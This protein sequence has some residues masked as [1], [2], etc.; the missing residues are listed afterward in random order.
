S[1]LNLNNVAEAG[2]LLAASNPEHRGWEWR[3]FMTRLDGARAVLRHSD[4][5]WNVSFNRDG[6]RL[7]SASRDG[8]FRVWDS[9]TG[10]ELFQRRFSERTEGRRYSFV[11]FLPDGRL[12]SVSSMD[13]ARIWKPD[14]PGA[15]PDAEVPV[16]EVEIVWFSPNGD[17][18]A[19]WSAASSEL[20]GWDFR[21]NRA[22]ERL[23]KNVVGN[24]E[25]SRDSQLMAMPTDGGDFVTW[26]VARR[27]VIRRFTG[28][29][30]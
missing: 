1:A 13:K 30:I 8:G 27:S 17:Y 2:R 3:H 16:G 26:D 23:P 15:P 5:V 18:M 12:L 7:A 10:Q 11:A 24:I 21:Q 20:W 6:T 28:H 25:F 4:G 19:W 22:P 14:A 9:G 29:S